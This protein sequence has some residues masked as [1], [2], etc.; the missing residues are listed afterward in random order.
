MSNADAGDNGFG[1]DPIE[2]TLSFVL[3]IPRGDEAPVRLLDHRGDGRGDV[4]AGQQ[5]VA[6]PQSHWNLVESRLRVYLNQRLRSGDLQ[7]G[8]WRFGENRLPESFGKEIAILL[9]S[10][11]SAAVE[12]VSRIYANWRRLAPEERQWL[13]GRVAVAPHQTDPDVGWRRAVQI[14]LLEEP[15]PGIAQH[16]ANS[17]GEHA[18]PGLPPGRDSAST[19][20]R[21]NLER[22]GQLRLL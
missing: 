17:E 3:H 2:Q 18:G 20:R 22:A 13:Y 5:Y 21:K 11:E 6:I 15:D 12:Q 8:V 1:Y 14:A 19:R 4:A 7:A 16:R 9:W 10:L